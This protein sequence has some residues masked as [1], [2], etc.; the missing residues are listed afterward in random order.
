MN[1]RALSAFLI[2][3]FLVSTPLSLSQIPFS[4]SFP[5]FA[6]IAVVMYGVFL[7][8]G[9]IFVGGA[10]RYKLLLD[11]YLILGLA[12]FAAGPPTDYPLG[13]EFWLTITFTSAIFVGLPAVMLLHLNQE[14]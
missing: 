2:G 9:G 5:L 3:L 8:A 12:L 11:F 14:D 10:E 6:K 13:Q 4:F 1:Q 7:I